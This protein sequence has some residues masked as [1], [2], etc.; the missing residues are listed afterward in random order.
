V[1]PVTVLPEAVKN[2]AK[3]IAD[4]LVKSVGL[5][6]GQFCTSPGLLFLIEGRGT[7]QFL[8][9]LRDGLKGVPAHC[10]LHPHIK[11]HYLAARRKQY[12]GAHHLLVPEITPDN[13]ITPALF[14]ITGKQFIAEPH[15]QEEVFG[16]FLQVV[17]CEDQQ[18]WVQCLSLL[19]GQ[20]TGSVFYDESEWKRA[21]TLIPLLRNKV[22]RLIFNGVPTGVE[23]SPAQQH[24]GGFPASTD[25]RFTAVGADAIAR[26]MHPV[27][28][29][30]CPEELLPE[31]L[32][33]T[34]P[35][36]ILRFV[37]GLLTSEPC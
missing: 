21:K 19:N 37:N 1:N 16:A 31:P 15:R 2:S 10:M 3:E 12:D 5:N 35:L 24:G 4:K 9:L 17:R 13:F 22:G 23:V 18:E 6:A 36:G 32:K 30:N 14:S 33:R 8:Y 25:N 20:L 11:E 28:F 26:F 29:Q 7:E 34:N 27:S